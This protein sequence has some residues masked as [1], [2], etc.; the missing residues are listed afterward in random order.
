MIARG[1]G[2]HHA[3]GP[4]RSIGIGNSPARY[5]ARS[6]PGSR[7]APTP[8]MPCWSALD[9]GGNRQGDA[10][11]S[12]GSI[13]VEALLRLATQLAG[14]DHAAQRRNRGVVRIAE[15]VVERVEDR[16]RRVEADEVEQ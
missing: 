7:S 15:L 11:G 12:D 4:V 1:S 9:A 14:S 13:V 5:A 10:G 2:D 8:T 3:I 6:V 16:E